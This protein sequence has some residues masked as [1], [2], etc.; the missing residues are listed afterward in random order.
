LL[1]PGDIGQRAYEIEDLVS[2]GELKQALRRLID[3][4]V[5]FSDIR[6]HRNSAVVLSGSFSTIEKKDRENLLNIEDFFR[7]NQKITINLLALRDEII[8]RAARRTLNDGA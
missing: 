6:E 2:N 5:D 7:F 1:K 4:A 3:F 8:D